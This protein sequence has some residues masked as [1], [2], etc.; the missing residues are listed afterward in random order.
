M[1]VQERLTNGN[2]FRIL[3]SEPEDDNYYL[4][5]KDNEPRDNESQIN[6][7]PINAIYFPTDAKLVELGYWEELFYLN[8]EGQRLS[9]GWYYRDYMKEWAGGDVYGSGTEVLGGNLIPLFREGQTIKAGT[10]LYAPQ[11]HP[12][13]VIGIAKNDNKEYVILY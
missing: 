3:T 12:F 13:D 7:L 6:K 8:S 2:G 4:T 1:S 5:Y 11:G 10:W 9:D